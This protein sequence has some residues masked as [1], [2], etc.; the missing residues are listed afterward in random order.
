MDKII[1]EFDSWWELTEL[2]EKGGMT[3]DPMGFQG[4]QSV[5]GI[6]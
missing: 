6:S 1:N 2:L 3:K 5:Q 4:L